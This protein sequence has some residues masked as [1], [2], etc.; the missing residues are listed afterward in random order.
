MPEP[1]KAELPPE[2]E[3]L[4]PFPEMDLDDSLLDD[5]PEVSEETTDETEE[6]ADEEV[7]ITEETEETTTPEA[8]PDED[9][10]EDYDA[11]LKP[12]SEDVD[13]DTIKDPAQRE[14][15]AQ[16][17]AKL[18]GREAK[19]LRAKLTEIELER[20]RDLEELETA[21]KELET[22]RTSQV[23][24]RTNPEYRSQVE[25]VIND[26]RE[27][28]ELLPVTDG[29]FSLDQKFGDYMSAYLKTQGAEPKV[30]QEAL[31]DLKAKI[32]DE[33]GNFDLPYAELFDEDKRLA[34]SLVTGVLQIV[35]RNV[36]PTRKLQELAD[37][38]QTRA[39]KGQLEHGV[40]SYTKR[41]TEISS[42]I[43]TFEAV[44]DD[45]IESDPFSPA[46]V[47]AKM[48]RDNPDQKVR[49]KKIE[50]D[51]IEAIEGPRPLTQKEL[52]DL[53]TKGV[54]LKEFHKQRQRQAEEK[55]RKLVVMLGQ[56]L[57][58]RAE[59]RQLRKELAELKS[60][61]E[62]ESS[63]K[64]ALAKVNKAPKKE[65]EEF[66]GAARD[67]PLPLSILGFR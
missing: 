67:R 45:V 26:V 17:Q 22:F 54:D 23:D 50:R 38:I 61:A 65:P 55:K 43:G 28:A 18:K 19:E 10:E 47:V 37:N 7:E 13:L 59:D 53:D 11:P 1:V 29:K 2:I 48:I 25:S 3:N 51:I 63:E 24:P 35:Q 62:G 8:E 52:D 42:L 60:K 21:R 12:K 40:E 30:K 56:H 15:I 58:T 41:A 66:K 33:I 14:S 44:A 20:K 27:G 16:Q 46:S 6:T 36:A 64:K 32:V 39:K 57:M 49:V 9:A 5:P 31:K 34:D 4:Y